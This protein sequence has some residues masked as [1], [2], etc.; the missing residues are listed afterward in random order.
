MFKEETS[1]PDQEN[2]YFIDQKRFILPLLVREY[3]FPSYSSSNDDN[4]IYGHQK[5]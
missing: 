5:C 2:I 1:H 3:I 4:N